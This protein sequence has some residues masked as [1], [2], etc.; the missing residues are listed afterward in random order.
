MA[1]QKCSLKLSPAIVKEYN[2]IP[3]MEVWSDDT[4][5]STLQQ[6]AYYRHTGAIRD[7]ATINML[8]D[9]LEAMLN[10]LQAQAASGV[11]SVAAPGKKAG[12]AFVLYYNPAYSGHNSI[13]TEAD[14]QQ[15][16]FVNHCVLNMMMTHD[17][18]FCNKTRRY[19]DETVAQS[20]LISAGGDDPMREIYFE[21]QRRR[22]ACAREGL[23]PCVS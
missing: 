3:G 15:T 16:V 23:K 18:E 21:D 12:A 20:R 4:F 5:T 17:P 1:L 19:F 7:A 14:G 13:Y 11:K 6:I 22:L 9:Q 2:N 8:Y 10:T